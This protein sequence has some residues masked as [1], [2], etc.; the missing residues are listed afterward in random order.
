CVHD[1]A[2]PRQA[3]AQAQEALAAGGTVVIMDERTTDTLGVGDP[4]QT[5]FACASVMWCLPQ[6][7][8]DPDSEAVGTG[9]TAARLREIAVSAGWSDLDILPIDHPFF[10]FYRLVG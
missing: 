8:V 9:M 6:G 10:R 2:H 4:V 7:R 3:L 5:F 1:M